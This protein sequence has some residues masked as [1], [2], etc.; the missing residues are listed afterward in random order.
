MRETSL[1]AK[2][3][4]SAAQNFGRARGGNKRANLPKNIYIPF[5]L[6][7]YSSRLDD[8]NGLELIPLEHN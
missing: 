6:T 4:M 1:N 3:W 8:L 2:A 5:F 7:Y